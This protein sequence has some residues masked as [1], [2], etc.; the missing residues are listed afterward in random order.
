M[1]L[2]SQAPGAW[3]S[4]NPRERGWLCSACTCSTPLLTTQGTRTHDSLSTGGLK[5]DGVKIPEKFQRSILGSAG[6]CKSSWK[7]VLTRSSLPAKPAPSQVQGAAT[8]PAKQGMAGDIPSQGTTSLLLSCSGA[9]LGLYAL[10]APKLLFIC[11]LECSRDQRE[12]TIHREEKNHH[13]HPYQPVSD[14]E[15]LTSSRSDALRKNL[16]FRC[17]RVCLS[18]HFKLHLSSKTDGT[19]VALFSWHLPGSICTAPRIALQNAAAR[20]QLLA[21][22]E[23]YIRAGGR[24]EPL[25][26]AAS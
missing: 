15:P 5:T 21:K 4:L 26:P 7:L 18:R 10:L 9:C 19:C 22:W 20:R 14:T 6:V 17:R 23:T 25:D 8:A 11:F 16:V 2:S 3:L 12:H 24:A 13:R 1:D